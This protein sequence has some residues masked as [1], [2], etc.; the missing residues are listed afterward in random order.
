MK[1]ISATHN[2]KTHFTRNASSLHGAFFISKEVK[3]TM[4]KNLFKRGMAGLLSLVMCLTALVG[5]GTTTAYAAGERAEVYLVSFPRSGDANID[6]SGTWGHPNLRYMNGWHSG[7]SKHTTIRAM[8]S[9]DGIGC[10]TIQLW[11]ACSKYCCSVSLNS[12]S[13][14]F[15]P[16]F[17]VRTLIGIG[18]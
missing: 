18:H 2:N 12:L 15:S 4:K 16:F 1:S 3:N 8:H 7:E 9:Y 17:K 11:S 14:R 13:K 5:I 6:Y 10:M